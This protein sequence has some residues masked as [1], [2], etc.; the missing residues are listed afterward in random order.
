MATAKI[1]GK[2]HAALDFVHKAEELSLLH[3][4]SQNDEQ[5]MAKTTAVEAK[6]ITE[7][8][9]VIELASGD[10]LPAV[11]LTEAQKLNELKDVLEGRDSRSDD[12]AAGGLRQEKQK[13]RA[14]AQRATFAKDEPESLSSPRRDKAG[15]PLQ[16][17]LPP[18]L[19][20]PLFP[21]LPLYG[22]PSLLRTLQCYIFRIT[23]FFLSLGFLA[24]IVLGS[25]FTS[26]PLMCQNIWMRLQFKDPKSRR[27]FYQEE[28]KRRKER[29]EAEKAWTR[30]RKHRKCNT[31]KQSD[32]EE[33]AGRSE[34]YN[35][36]EGG[37]DPLICDV[38]YYARRVG[39]DIEEFKVQTE[40][41]FI[42]DL[43]HVYNPEEYT[44]AS[45]EDRQFRKPDVFYEDTDEDNGTP[46]SRS[47]RGKKYPI[48]MMH[49]L[50]QSAGA[51]CCNDDD[52][53]AFFLA[54]RFVF[55]SHAGVKPLLMNAVATMSGLG[56]TGAVST[57]STSFL[58]TAI[59]AS[60]AGISGNPP[61]I[62]RPSIPKLNMSSDKWVSS[63]S[64]L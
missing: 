37:K 22:P 14:A 10:R 64:Q 46:M 44:P 49:G 41:G 52:S 62:H 33:F 2:A 54:K 45:K 40:D 18:S 9:P 53:L 38:G 31:E 20:N 28:E 7:S 43:W 32:R 16:K 35:P 13:E 29:R 56:T 17:S 30:D 15:V 11:P 59:L 27:I 5:G 25:G 34:D 63:T 6:F 3:P 12:T 57:P 26:I 1:E 51:Y 58:S 47:K 39:L 24:V 61:F 60:G 36:T 21:P 50:L 8:D 48:L 23:S 55:P 19:T 4:K 42:I